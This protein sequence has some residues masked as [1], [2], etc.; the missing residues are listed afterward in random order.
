MYSNEAEDM[1]MVDSMMIDISTLR[2]ATNDFD[3]SNKLGGGEGGFGAVYKV[4]T[5]RRVC[6]SWE[7]VNGKRSWI[8]VFI[9]ICV[10]GVLP[11]GDEIAVK[12]LS[13]CSTQGIEELKNEL[14]LVAKLKHKNLVRLVGI[15]L[16]QQ[17]RLLI[18]EFVANRSLDLIL[19]GIDSIL[20]KAKL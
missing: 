12:R 13:Q 20:L 9:D 3:E 6:M 1:E 18:Y 19:F 10:Q 8:F 2:A 5:D 7:F 16:E 15:C 14:A 11:D 17:E 4:V